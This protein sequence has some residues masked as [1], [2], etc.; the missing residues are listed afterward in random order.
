MPGLDRYSFRLLSEEVVI[1]PLDC[2]EE[3]WETD[4]ADFL[5][6][7]ALDQQNRGLNKTYLVYRNDAFV[8]FVSLVSSS[9]KPDDD[10]DIPDVGYPDAPCLLVGRLGIQRD[11]QSQGIGSSIL[12][13]VRAEAVSA[14]FGV[15]FVVLH[16]ERTNRRARTFYQ[17]NGF[18][19]IDELSDGNSLFYLFDLYG[20]GI[21]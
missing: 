10:E 12:S 18:R 7:D 19:R 3:E 2:G 15:R 8:G 5:R 13:W 17:D 1:P 21:I 11:V 9:I 14:R 6:D 16:V 4:V 20:S